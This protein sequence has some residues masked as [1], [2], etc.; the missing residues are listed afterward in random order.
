[1]VGAA[2]SALMPAA[3]V[4]S[5]FAWDFLTPEGLRDSATSIADADLWVRMPLA[6]NEHLGMESSARVLDIPSLTFPAFHPDLVYATTT[7]GTLFRGIN[8]YHSAIAL[9]A[10]RHGVQPSDVRHLF[11]PEVM[12]RLTY[13]QYWTPSVAN[14]KAEFAR[15]SLDFSTFWLRVKREGVFMHSVNHPNS[16]AVSLLAKS[17]LVALGASDSVWV[18][19][20][21]EYVDDTLSHIVWPVYPFVASALGVQGSYRWRNGSS[22]FGGID[23]W[24]EATWSAYGDVTPDTVVC[25]RIDDGVYEKV[26]GEALM[27]RSAVL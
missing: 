19:P 21:S 13:D 2:L 16:A 14:M 10:W 9:W 1:M 6:E 3:E 26:L 7:D 4:T 23:E 27:T 8:D 17:A 20:V 18:D 22:L 24:A 11:T 5:L 15:S 12:S 25:E